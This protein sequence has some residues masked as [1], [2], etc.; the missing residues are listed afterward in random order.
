MSKREILSSIFDSAVAQ[1]VIA[2][3]LL[4][5]ALFACAG[6]YQA[7]ISRALLLD[8]VHNLR[9]LTV[10]AGVTFQD[11]MAVVFG[12][13][14]GPLGRPVSMLSF[15]MDHQG[16]EELDAPAF[17]R[18]NILIHLITAL[19]LA[20]LSLQILRRYEAYPGQASIVA[21]FVGIAWAMHPENISTVQYI[22]QR[23][24]QLSAMFSLLSLIS[25]IYGRRQVGSNE[26]R[27]LFFLCL[28][29]FPFALLAVFSKENA[30]ML[31]LIFFILEKTI[32]TDEPRPRRFMS[33][34]RVCVLAALGV[35]ALG[36]LFSMP[37]FLEDYQY[38]T[39]TMWERQ[40]TQFRVL[41]MQLQYVFL[42]DISAFTLYHDG[43]SHSTSLFN[44]GTTFLS[45]ILHLF[46]L[47]CAFRFRNSQP[48]FALAIFWYYGWH[49][50]ESTVVP[51]E[52]HFEHRNYLP[53]MGPILGAIYYASLALHKFKQRTVQVVIRG[54]VLVWV[55]VLSFLT[56]QLNT[57]WANPAELAYH[58][59]VVNEDSRRSKIQLAYYYSNGHYYDEG[60]EVL[61]EGLEQFP[62]EI[63]ML[64]EAWN[65]A[66][67]HGLELPY[68]LE[69]VAS[70][71]PYEYTGDAVSHQVNILRW[72]LMQNNCGF[73][74]PETFNTIIGKIDQLNM[75]PQVRASV[76]FDASGVIVAMD[77]WDK[78]FR[79]LQRA[80]EIDRNR[81]ILRQQILFAFFIEDFE[82]ADALITLAREE[83]E[84]NSWNS[85]SFLREL[86]KMQ[87]S[88]RERMA[89][90]NGATPAVEG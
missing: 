14:S 31:I 75:Q 9:P 36:F 62:N 71:E 76:Y 3:T 30:V 26:V 45:L 17:R 43:M 47:G 79:L 27:G 87:Q 65:F 61:L 66:C 29:Y 69:D 5:V 53:M 49:L 16:G 68:T 18:T 15:W 2:I 51:L 48:V 21:A 42:P 41:A 35:I 80:Y 34:Y 25:Y 40:L 88:A 89:S 72:N 23:M 10:Q 7:G 77:D 19:A 20:V 11:A 83:A 44:P 90:D 63:T 37:G 33:W 28:A 39:F 54:G 86:D 85:P 24:T 13:E 58:W 12:N 67:Q 82:A 50:I 38:R 32:F 84:K 6:I 64:L 70:V 57:L 55:I 1:R 4:L 60:L 22:V 78:G 74:E 8:S 59:Y 56:L 73:V 52:L 81:Y 46:L